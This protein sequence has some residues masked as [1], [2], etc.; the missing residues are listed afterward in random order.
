LAIH[1]KGKPFDADVIW[2]A[3]AKRT[4]GFSGADLEN[5][6]NEA[7]IAVARTNRDKITMKDID[8]AA[9]KA[10][11]GSEKR[12]AQTDQ[13]KLMTAYHEAGHAIVNY[14]EHLDPVTRI[15]IVSRGMALGFTLIPP[16]RDEV[17]QT[18][19]NLIKKMAMAMGGR[20]AEEVIFGDISTGASSDISHATAIARDMVVEWGM[21]EL[22]PIN[23]GPQ[24]DISDFG[25]AYIE[26]AKIS[27]NMQAK[28]DEEIKKIV[29][30]A[31]DEAV[32]IVKKNKSKLDKLAKLL[33]EKESIGQEEFEKCVK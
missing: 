8:E 25:K 27:D 31:H 12:R 16:E 13:D 5:M 6:L 9:L 21:S 4:V 18:K 20:A 10:K 30:A 15:S 3:V 32:V 29:N 19:S 2:D 26:P 23:Y 11:L 1:A 17:H 24:I 33:V 28:V 22:G 7:A 14:C